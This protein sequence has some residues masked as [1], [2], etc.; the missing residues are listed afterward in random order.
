MMTIRTTT[1]RNNAKI[2]DP[3]MVAPVFVSELK[4]TDGDP[5]TR[6]SS[7]A[8]RRYTSSMREPRR[9]AQV[10]RSIAFRDIQPGRS[11]RDSIYA[12]EPLDPDRAAPFLA[13]L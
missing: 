3:S 8:S 1:N 12:R 11:R 7:L 9:V 10:R 5:T 4:F 13:A 2:D 6:A